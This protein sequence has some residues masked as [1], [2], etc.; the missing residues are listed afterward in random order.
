MRSGESGQLHVDPA[1][2]S[3]MGCEGR[4]E[5]KQVVAAPRAVRRSEDHAVGIAD[6]DAREGQ[7]FSTRGYGMLDQFIDFEGTWQRLRLE[8][9]PAHVH[10]R[11]ANRSF[12]IDLRLD[13]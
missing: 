2:E 3:R 1:G 6:A 5:P 13:P 8:R 12:R 9:C 7:R 11:C 4:A 10:G